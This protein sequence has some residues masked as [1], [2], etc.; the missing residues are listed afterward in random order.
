[1]VIDELHLVS[2]PTRGATLERLLTKAGITSLSHALRICIC[3]CMCIRAFNGSP[4]LS[5]TLAVY[6]NRTLPILQ[7]MTTIHDH[8]Q[9]HRQ[10]QM[11]VLDMAGRQ[12]DV[13][14]IY[15]RRG[16]SAIAPKGVSHPRR[17]LRPRLLPT[18]K[19]LMRQWAFIGLTFLELS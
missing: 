4:Q 17:R 9:S 2:D 5:L 19:R 13:L 1:M 18:S 15:G 8:R 3:I 6:G 10:S 12:A 16:Y 7:C 11:S 14:L